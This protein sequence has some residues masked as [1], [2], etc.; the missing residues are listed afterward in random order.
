MAFPVPGS[1]PAGMSAVTSRLLGVVLIALMAVGSV[2]LWFAVPFGWV[3]LASRT[4]A[5]SQPTMA[6]ILMIILGIPATMFVVAK[7]LSALDRLYARVMGVPRVRVRSPWL[8]SMRDGR[9]S[10]RPRT[11]LDVVMVVSVMVALA[12]FGVWFLFFAEGGGI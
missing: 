10:G 2:A 5:S 8:R 6:P 9:D 1:L 7:G 3:Y 12:C 4:V 11:V